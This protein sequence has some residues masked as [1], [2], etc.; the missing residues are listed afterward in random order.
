MIIVN[1]KTFIRGLLNM[2]KQNQAVE[3]QVVESSENPILVVD[4]DGGLTTNENCRSLITVMSVST[5][6]RL[7]K[8]AS[9][10][11]ETA[12]GIPTNAVYREFEKKDSVVGIFIGTGLI[13]PKTKEDR[14]DELT[15]EIIPKGTRVPVPTIQ[16]MEKDGRVYQNGGVAL[17]SEF[18]SNGNYRI[19]L[20]SKVRITYSEKKGDCKLYDVEIL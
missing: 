7:Q 18:I 5:F 14:I 16:W 9:E 2:A 8:E 20:N 11:D 17:F 1:K 19:P 12:Q 10:L 13:T 3:T 4:K 6:Q 15:G